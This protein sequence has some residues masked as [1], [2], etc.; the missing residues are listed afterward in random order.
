M[1]LV[2]CATC[3]W[4]VGAA[5]MPGTTC[6]AATARAGRSG[7]L[8]TRKSRTAS[9]AAQPLRL[10]SGRFLLLLGRFIGVDDLARLK[11]RRPNHHPVLWIGGLADV[12]AGHILPLGQKRPGLR[13]FS[14]L[15]EGHVARDGLER[16]TTDVVRDLLMI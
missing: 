9:R 4:R 2:S 1:R 7:R 10:R 6:V 16:V 8:A 14:V 5:D 12:V 11:F 3:C 15:A 13:P